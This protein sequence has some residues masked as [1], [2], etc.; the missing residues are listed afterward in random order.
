MK[1][2]D[3]KDAQEHYTKDDRGD[4]TGAF[5][6]FVAEEPSSMDQEPRNM[7][8]GG[9]LVQ[10]SDDGS[11]P[12]YK[13]IK[14]YSPEIQKIVNNY[15]IEKYNKLSTQNKFRVRDGQDVGSLSSDKLKKNVFKKEYDKATKFYKDKG[16]QIDKAATEN[17]RKNIRINN[18]KFVAPTK[19]LKA[20]SGLTGL[21]KNYS[22]QQLVKDLKVGK[23]PYEIAIEYFNNNET[24]VLELLEG[25]K[26]YTKPLGRLS[27]DLL[28]KIKQNKE[29]TKFYNKIK[30]E[31]SFNKP[32][33]SS[34]YIKDL[35]TLLPY[36]Q[37]K[38]LI[39]KVNAKGMPINT[40][41]K[42]FNYAY[43]IK[44]D[45]IAKLFNYA[46]KVGIEHP[47]GVARAVIFNDFG[48][49]NDIVA[50]LPE[51][52][53]SKGSSFD[54]FATGQATSFKNTGNSKYIKSIN[55]ITNQAFKEFGTPRS[56]Y[57]IKGGVVT[58]R[59]TGFSLSNPNIQKDAKSFIEQYIAKDGSKRPSF[60]KLDKT[61]QES[62][63]AY[64]KGNKIEGN[65]K[66]K[67]SINNLV[68]ELACGTGKKLANGGRINFNK[69]SSCN[70][71]GRKILAEGLKTGFKKG[72][73][74]VL[75]TAILKA[76]KGLKDIASIRALLGPAAVGFIAAEQA[77]Y[78]SYDM[79]SKGKSFREAIGDS[80]FNYLTGDKTKVDS[81]KERNKRMIKEGMTLE[82]MGKIGAMESTFDRINY[83]NTL[84]QKI[85]DA[86]Q[87]QLDEMSEDSDF[88]YLPN[89]TDEFK[90]QEDEARTNLR[91][92][93]RGN[94][95]FTADTEGGQKALAEGL[96]R[97]ELAQLQS[98]DNIFQSKKGDLNRA[99]RKRE[100]MLQN[101][102]I[103][104]YMG[105]YPT[106]LGFAG[107]GIAGLSG[108]DK[109]GPPPESGPASQGLRSLIKNG[110]KL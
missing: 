43:K 7:Y 55:K 53:V 87:G 34:K 71:R 65:K 93:Y 105:P 42:Y 23:G 56:I 37:E 11:R 75:A 27:N 83:G 14:D 63:L 58:A 109:S 41:S 101:P 57:D 9:Q 10:P 64:E 62:I 79:L 4:A 91:E 61:L 40:A 3:Y 32:T 95:N 102:D 26:G 89:R 28:L 88:S 30:K 24:E 39:P 20:E 8:A 35:E 6:M 73:Q 50:T 108:G 77:A 96:R 54:K 44:A 21:F 33:S 90:K 84:L 69:G 12:G 17:I 106:T 38:G 85:E 25:K 86:K 49:L 60:K 67:L 76:G 72:N 15:G 107:G 46:E 16:L 52:N 82:Q 100:L 103:L 51:S 78:V 80:A 1:I 5:E 97:N 94:T 104:N 45:P 22:E 110:R 48:T 59:D 98:V 18:G 92:F 36:A 81:I 99:Q 29:A 70:V 2:K 74:A 47:R 13:G 19:K 31:N 68:G 66:L